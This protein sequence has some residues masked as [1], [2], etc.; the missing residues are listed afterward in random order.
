[1]RHFTS[2]V[3]A[4]EWVRNS[5]A[6]TEGLSEAQARVMPEYAFTGAEVFSAE[7]LAVR[8]AAVAVEAIDGCTTLHAA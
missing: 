7:E 1:M 2:T 8:A 6:Y 5:P 3:E 4:A